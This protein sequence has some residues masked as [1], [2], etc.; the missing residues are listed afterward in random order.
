MWNVLIVLCLFIKDPHWEGRWCDIILY[1]SK[2]SITENH[3]W[4][5]GCHRWHQRP[6]KCYVHSIWTH[7]RTP[8]QLPQVYAAHIPVH[9]AGT[10]WLRPQWTKTKDPNIEK[11][12]CNVKV[13]GHRSQRRP[14]TQ[15]ISLCFHVEKSCCF[16]WVCFVQGQIFVVIC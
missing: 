14:H 9:T 1:A 16:I 3:H 5:R 10:S 8:S 2:S 13:I 7:T 4:G 12:A 6:A 11:L 15:V